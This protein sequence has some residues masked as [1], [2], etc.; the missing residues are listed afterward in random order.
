[1]CSGFLLRREGV[2]MKSVIYCDAILAQSNIWMLH[3]GE[4][5]EEIFE[6]TSRIKS[7]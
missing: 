7:N 6:A 5:R 4:E 2:N 3:R 1:M